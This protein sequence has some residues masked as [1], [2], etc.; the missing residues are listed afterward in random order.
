MKYSKNELEVEILF[1]G[2]K[3]TIQKKEEENEVKR[4]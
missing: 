2:E 1:D 4:V 3:I